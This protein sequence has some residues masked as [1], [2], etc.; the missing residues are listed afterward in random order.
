MVLHSCLACASVSSV[1]AVGGAGAGL[2]RGVQLLA[3]DLTPAVQFRIGLVVLLALAVGTSLAFVLVAL[4]RSLGR[5]A[6]ELRDAEALLHDVSDGIPLLM[7]VT[8]GRGQ[9]VFVNR[10]FLDRTG[11]SMD[12]SLG[13]GWLRALHPDDQVEIREQVVRAGAKPEGG[14]IT[15]RMATSGG[16]WEPVLESVRARRDSAGVFTGYVCCTIAESVR[17]PKVVGTAAHAEP[18]QERI[19]A[20]VVAIAQAAGLEVASPASSTGITAPSMPAPLE[21]TSGETEDGLTPSVLPGAIAVR[22]Y[23]ES[24]AQG[25]LSTLHGILDCSRISAGACDE[26]HDDFE[27]HELV[28]RVL[29]SVAA[30]AAGARLN[31]VY[32]WEAGVPSLAVGDPRRLEQVLLHVLADVVDYAR[33]S[34]VEIRVT[35]V[36]DELGASLRFEV[37]DR[38][39]GVVAEVRHAAFRRASEAVFLTRQTDAQSLSLAIAHQFVTTMNGAMGFTRTLGVGSTIWFTVGVGRSQNRS[40]SPV[41]RIDRPLDGLPVTIWISSSAQGPALAG[42]LTRWGAHV[43]VVR[44]PSAVWTTMK[45]LHRARRRPVL[46]VDDAVAG[47]PGPDASPAS[48]DRAAFVDDVLQRWPSTAVVNL[49]WTLDGGADAAASNVV[50][51]PASTAGHALV[52]LARPVLPSALLATM[53][54]LRATASEGATQRRAS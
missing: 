25:F 29:T 7:R 35:A 14:S 24:A 47:R 16:G 36:H 6:S 31:I 8:D 33:A 1:V 30:Q 21:S 11:L 10:A 18:A 46:M 49:T 3:L 44:E 12:E 54:S 15:Y 22:P 37:S 28:E 43:D 39:V 45:R 20:E 50:P 27:L 2:P 32:S 26:R 38:T 53:L 42:I 19:L 48:A 40:R 5:T 41:S 52:H 9:C 23:M 4:L 51:W 17:M 34:D 13:D